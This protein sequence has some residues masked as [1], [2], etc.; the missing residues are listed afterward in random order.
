MTRIPFGAPGT[1]L[2]GRDR[3]GTDEGQGWGESNVIVS[4]PLPPTSMW[5]HVA[6]VRDKSLECSSGA[7]RIP[8]LSSVTVMRVAYQVCCKTFFFVPFRL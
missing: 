5:H 8:K 7:K 6:S 1:P 4:V 3:D 2:V